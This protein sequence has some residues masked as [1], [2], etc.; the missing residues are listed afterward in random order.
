MIR[1]KEEIR[2]LMIKKRE[3]MRK[4]EVL[5]KSK[6]IEERFLSSDEFAKSDRIAIYYPIRNEV[7]T[8]GIIS[9]LLSK[10]KEVYLPITREEITLGRIRSFSEL[11]PGK[12]NIMEPREA[13]DE[14]VNLDLIVVPGVAFD[15]SGY[16]LG[17]GKGYYDRFL[18][19][20]RETTK[21]GLAYEFQVLEEVPRDEEDIPV[22]FIITEKRRI[23]CLKNRKKE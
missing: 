3:S 16:R 19:S 10:G 1:A 9:W 14:E 11:R 6:K 5:E 15:E 13:I 20:F 7:D 8:R 22:D 23:D 18:R 21:L 4:E 17:F 2:R 12:F